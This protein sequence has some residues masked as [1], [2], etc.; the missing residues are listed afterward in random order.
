M[1][2]EDNLLN[3]KIDIFIKKL[4]RN[5]LGIRWSKGNWLS[6]IDS[7]KLTNQIKWSKKISHK[8]LKFFVA[9]LPEGAPAKLLCLNQSG[10]LRN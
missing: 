3:D 2:V 4:Q 1:S 8:I 6:N 5:I 10:I 9:R 7:Y